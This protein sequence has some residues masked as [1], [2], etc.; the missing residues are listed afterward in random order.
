M[1]PDVQILIIGGGLSGLSAALHLVRAGVEDV[2]VLEAERIGLGGN[3]YLS[4]TPGPVFPDYTKMVLTPDD[5]GYTYLSRR[6]NRQV[7][8]NLMR[9]KRRG[10]ELQLQL[11]REFDPRLVRQYGTLIVGEPDD[12]R[13]LREE[14]RVMRDLGIDADIERYDA[15]RIEALYG[16]APGKYVQGLFVTGDAI[17]DSTRY[18]QAIARSLGETRYREQSRV[19][20]LREEGELVRAELEGGESVSAS[21]VVVATNGFIINRDANLSGRMRSYW[22]FLVA[23][24]DPGE[25]TPNAYYFDPRAHYWARQ[26][27]KLIV[28]GGDT[29][30]VDDN[31]HAPPNAARSAERLVRWCAETFPR[32]AGRRELAL[33]YSVFGETRDNLPILGRFSPQS[34]LWYVVGDNGDGQSTLSCI[35]HLLPRA[36]GFAQPSAEEEALIAFLSPGRESL[37]EPPAKP[38][39]TAEIASGPA[40]NP[41]E[42]GGLEPSGSDDGELQQTPEDVLT[43]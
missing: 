38:A 3:T 18:V 34:R 22:T 29:P 11:A 23:F 12:E 14:H 41:A 2:F 20:A 39:S 43:P 24:D 13:R 35:A 37:K 26:D 25:N 36:M 33:H 30:V 17:V 21:H 42:R 8:L 16:A 6:F 27:G 5:R 9:V 15:G 19:V 28:G 32:L 4:G 1:Q 10:V 40:M 31:F 7:A